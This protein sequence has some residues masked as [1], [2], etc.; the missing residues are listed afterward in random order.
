VTESRKVLEGRGTDIIEVI[1]WHLSKARV[2][3][4]C[5]GIPLNENLKFKY[6]YCQYVFYLKKKELKLGRINYSGD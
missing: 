6:L 5:A 4:F 2:L 3:K 1:S